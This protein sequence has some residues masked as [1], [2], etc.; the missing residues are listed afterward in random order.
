[1]TRAWV[2]ATTNAGVTGD[3]QVV[4]LNLPFSFSFYGTSYI[5]VKVSSNGNVHFGSSNKAH[6]NTC[7]PRTNAPRPMIAAFWDDLYPPGGGA[8]YYG[9]TGTAP[10]RVF[11]VEW[12]DI[13]HYSSSPSGVTFEVQL[14]EGTNNIYVLYQDVD[15]GNTAYNDG[16]SATA[17]LQNGAATMALQYSCNQAVLA[18]KPVIR[19][20]KP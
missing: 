3:D 4:T 10:N 16:A 7:L 19:Y 6:S 18:A 20:F 5:S 1:V 14:E 8:V 11:T 9:A 13:P 17:G 15:F 12:R 2:A